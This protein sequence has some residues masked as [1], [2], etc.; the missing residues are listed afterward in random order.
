[1]DGILG[2]H[3]VDDELPDESG[4]TCYRNSHLR[5]SNHFD[6]PRTGIASDLDSVVLRTGQVWPS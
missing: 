4:S 6:S 5:D 1:M 2:T 3:S